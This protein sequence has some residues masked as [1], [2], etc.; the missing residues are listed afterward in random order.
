MWLIPALYLATWPL[1][2]VL[3]T[4]VAIAALLCLAIVDG[5]ITIRHRRGFAWT[6][7]IAAVLLFPALS[8]WA[9]IELGEAMP[10]QIVV[11]P[12]STC[13]LRF[14]F[15]T[16][17]RSVDFID[18]SCRLYAQVKNRVSGRIEGESRLTLTECS[19]FEHPQIEWLPQSVKVR[20]YR[21]AFAIPRKA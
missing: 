18:P 10:P 15:R 5:R 2:L 7:S 9:D 3:G 13:E 1:G 20:F 19:D 12:D 16:T 17:T 6:G 21:Y 8:F 11:S 14:S 4:P